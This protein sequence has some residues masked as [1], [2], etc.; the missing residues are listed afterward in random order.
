MDNS[1]LLYTYVDPPS[2]DPK[3]LLNPEYT[4]FNQTPLFLYLATLTS[5]RS[6]YTMHQAML[7]LTKVMSGQVDINPFYFPYW[8]LRRSHILTLRAR[9]QELYTPSTVNTYLSGLK[10]VLKE[11]WRLELMDREEYERA[12]DFKALPDEVQ[13]TGKVPPSD[14]IKALID[15]CR[16]HTRGGIFDAAIIEVLYTTGLRKAEVSN[17]NLE[18]LEEVTIDDIVYHRF[19]VLGKGRKYRFVYLPKSK[20]TSLNAWLRHRGT[21]PDDGGRVFLNPHVSDR[22]TTLHP[23]YI[24]DMLWRRQ[25]QLWGWAYDSKEWYRPHDFR[26]YFITSLLDAGVDLIF[27]SKLAGHARLETTKRYDY[28]EQEELARLLID[29]L[30]YL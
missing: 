11:C 7:T 1:I 26:R 22:Y 30:H 6:R 27:V 29:H 21:P 15:H 2:N 5:P 19:K 4:A 12:V 13:P 17:L 28:R 3:D 23:Q 16:D 14:V 9:L 24:Y 20:V 25:N 8:D 10:G 18:N